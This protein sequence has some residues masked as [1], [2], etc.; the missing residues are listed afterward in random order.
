M[1]LRLEIPIDAPAHRVWDVLGEQFMRIS[2]W[3]GPITASCPSGSGSPDI[4]AVR[5]CTVAAFGPIKPGAVKERL[6]AFDRGRMTFEYEALEEGMPAFIERA[7]NRWSVVPINDER[8]LVRTHATL[9]LRGP[10]RLLGFLIR[11]QLNSGG[12]RVLEELKYFV[13]NGKPHP[14]KV[15]QSGYAGVI[16]ANPS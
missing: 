1:E 11:W 3:A 8:S 14:R 13:E 16:N 15:A 2:E 9:T 6:T 7:V 4:G 5:S 12:A 10:Y